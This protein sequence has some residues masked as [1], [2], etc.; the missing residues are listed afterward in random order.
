LTLLEDAGKILGSATVK[1]KAE[2]KD[3]NN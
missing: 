1:T 3:I 2:K